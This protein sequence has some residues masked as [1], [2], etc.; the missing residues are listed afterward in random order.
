MQVAVFL[1]ASVVASADPSSAKGDPTARALLEADWLEQKRAQM[2]QERIDNATTQEDAAGG[3]DGVINGE[4]GFHCASGE[5]DSWWQVDLGRRC[6]LDRVVVYN[7]CGSAAARVSTGL[8]ILVSDD[9]RAWNEVYQHVGAV[10]YGFTDKKPL[11]VNFTGKNVAARFVRLQMRRAVS[12]HLDE[13][14]VYGRDDPTKNIALGRP[15]DQSSTSRYST[16]KVRPGTDGYTIADVRQILDAG[17][18]LAKE[19]GEL[20]GGERVKSAAER[21]GSLAERSKSPAADVDALYQ[22]ARWTVREIA[23]CNPLLDFDKLIFVKRH[24]GVFPHMCDQYYGCYASPGGGIFVLENTRGNIRVREIIGQEVMPGSYMSPDLSYDGHR[25]VFAHSRAT[26]DR[27]GGCWTP[28][29]CYH[30]FTINVDGSGLRQI[31]DGPHDDFDPRFLPDG[32]IVFISTRRGGFCRCGGRP[33]PTYTLHRA[34]PDNAAIRCISWH[35]T[36][37][38]NPSVLNDGNLIYTRW[39]YVD[40][41]TNVAHSLWTARSDGSNP[42]AFYGNYNFGKKP[43]GVWQARA[44][45]GSRKVLGIAG[46]HHGYAEGSV[47]LIDPADGQDGLEP[48]TRITPDVPFPE[49]EGWPMSNFTTLWPLSEDFYLVSYSPRWSSKRRSTGLTPGIYLLDR[50]GHKELLYR[51]PAIPSESPTPLQARPKPVTHSCTVDWAGPRTG[52]FLLHDVYQSTEPMER[53]RIKKLRVVQVLPKSTYRSDHPKIS[54]ARQI[55]ARHLLGAVPVEEDGSAY[56]EA[57]AGVPLYFQAVDDRDKAHQG[58]RTITYVQPGETL[59]CVGCHEPRNTTPPNRLPLA[60]RRPPSQIEPGPDGT[61]PLSYLRL[62]QPVLDKHCI[63]C[64]SGPEPKKGI[65]LTGK[66]GGSEAAHC[67]SYRTLATRERVHWFDSVNGGEWVPRTYP[68][69]FGAMAS[70]IIEMLDKGHN[71]VKLSP[72]EFRRLCIW[73]DLNIPFYGVYLPEHVEAQR[74]GEAVPVE[75]IMQ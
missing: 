70:P 66:L 32:D 10:F 21:L 55:S 46:A 18:R 74:R 51:D 40:R 41:H 24:T 23:L 16:R 36:N 3:V 72:D 33:V 5:P 8:V 49:A 63:K 22:E 71:D 59:S 69:K 31:T 35:E 61:R 37:E 65:R 19:I 27:K 15:A 7:R 62:V 13:I 26:G 14:E 11:V 48:V 64:H 1:T 56:F 53:G 2:T 6:A 9:G 75:A 17:Q 12:F 25:I 67:E 58:M 57:P 39:D 54:R 60:V 68:G 29:V 52:R 30:L 4:Y 73:I 43:W 45:P 20:G 38:W 42:M 28:E 50:W 44:I 47:V 34:S